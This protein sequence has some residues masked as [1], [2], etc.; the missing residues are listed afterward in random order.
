MAEITDFT[1]KSFDDFMQEKDWVQ[2]R[3]AREIEPLFW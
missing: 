1:E 2:F 3:S